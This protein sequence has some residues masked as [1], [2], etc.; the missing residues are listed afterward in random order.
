MNEQILHYIKHHPEATTADICQALAL[1]PAPG[2][3][4]VF[5]LA[6][7]G[8]VQCGFRDDLVPTFRTIEK[9]GYCEDCGLVDHHLVAGLCDQCLVGSNWREGDC[10]PAAETEHTLEAHS[11]D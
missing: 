9:V 6:R 10:C 3:M 2:V 1:Q 11:H 5:A 7:S 8:W 4:A